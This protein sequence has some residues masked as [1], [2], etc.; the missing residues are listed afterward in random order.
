MIRHDS[1][2]NQ[3]KLNK[4]HVYKCV[5]QYY[6]I[7][8]HAD[9]IHT[10]SL[11]LL[12]LPLRSSL[13]PSC[14]VHIRVRSQHS[15]KKS[16]RKN[17]E[18]DSSIYTYVLR[19][20]LALLFPPKIEQP[21]ISPSVSVT[22]RPPEPTGRPAAAADGASAIGRSFSFFLFQLAYVYMLCIPLSRSILYSFFFFFFF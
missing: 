8:E 4:R 1:Q 17:H 2:L 15:K 20:Q 9:C 22:L 7:R 6:T 10:F 13:L 3:N 21:Q 12:L 19:I 16:G 5:V 14:I 11:L 18:T